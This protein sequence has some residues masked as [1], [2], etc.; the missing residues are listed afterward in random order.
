MSLRELV[1]MEFTRDARK[2][3]SE[4]RERRRQQMFCCLLRSSAIPRITIL[5]DL[6]VKTGVLHRNI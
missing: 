3:G 4:G 1:G 5:S 6:G 2:G